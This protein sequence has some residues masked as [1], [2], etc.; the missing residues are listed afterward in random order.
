MMKFVEEKVELFFKF[1]HQKLLPEHIFRG[2]GGGAGGWGNSSQ[3]R[4]SG[5]WGR[6][7]GESRSSGVKGGELLPEQ[8]F[9]G[10]GAGLGETPPRADLQG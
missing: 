5:A 3:S 10:L 6:G 4:S 7:W 9:R 1:Q 8:I 2:K